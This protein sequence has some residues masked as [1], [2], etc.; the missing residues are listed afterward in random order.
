M[1]FLLLKMLVYP[2]NSSQVKI[3]FFESCPVQDGGEVGVGAQTE[4]VRPW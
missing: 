2:L 1:F 4:S 3:T